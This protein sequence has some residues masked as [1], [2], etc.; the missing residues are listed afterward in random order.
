MWE[1]DPHPRRMV[2]GSC[3][4]APLLARPPRDHAR[5]EEVV[6]VSHSAGVQGAP[7][8]GDLVVV[9]L[10]SSLAALRDRLA[11]DGFESAALLVADLV[12]IAD[13]YITNCIPGEERPS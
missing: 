11:E 9:L 2:G 8:I 1:D 4:Q 6:E 7:D 3:R 10:S 12:D 5:W 13:D